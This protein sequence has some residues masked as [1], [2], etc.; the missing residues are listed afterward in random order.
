M[1]LL[2]KRKENGMQVSEAP[3]K[4]N[5]CGGMRLADMEGN[6]RLVCDANQSGT[7]GRAG[8]ASSSPLL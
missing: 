4:S 2:K 3:T 5:C 1:E 6:E 8:L 7:F